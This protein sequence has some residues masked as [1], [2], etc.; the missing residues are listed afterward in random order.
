MGERGRQGKGRRK[1]G[2]SR[3]RGEG[4]VG[5]EGE[6]GGGGEVKNCLGGSC[7]Y[8]FLAS[9]SSAPPPGFASPRTDLTPTL[10]LGRAP[11]C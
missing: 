10:R 6:N 9:L 11:T 8:W 5:E 7:G 2:R 4:E 3:E 1:K